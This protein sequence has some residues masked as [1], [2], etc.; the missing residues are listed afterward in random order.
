MT[1]YF[2]DGGHD[3]RLPLAVAHALASARC[4]L[5]RQV[6]VASLACCMRYSSWSIVHS[7]LLE[8]ILQCPHINNN[9]VIII[10]IHLIYKA[11]CGRNL[12]RAEI[13]LVSE[14]DGRMV[15]N[16]PCLGQC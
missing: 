12:N 11:P 13:L 7:Y 6:R 14:M 9:I 4:R 15:R 2:Q 1:S 3:V 16:V 8:Y 10:I 5:A